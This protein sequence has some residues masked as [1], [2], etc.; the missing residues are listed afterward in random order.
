MARL[1][2]TDNVQ[3]QQCQGKGWYAPGISCELCRST[4][5]TTVK[6]RRDLRLR[7]KERMEE[8]RRLQLPLRWEQ[9]PAIQMDP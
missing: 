3:C 5:V 1:S 4:G 7:K 9:L 6:Q 8:L 2:D